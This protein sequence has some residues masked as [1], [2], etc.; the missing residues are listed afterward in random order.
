METNGSPSWTKTEAGKHL[1]ERLSDERTLASLDHLLERI[2]TL[3]QAVDRLA[4]LME[5]GPGLVSMAADTVDETYRQATARG[6]DL[7]QRLSNAAHLAEKLTA[8]ETIERIEGMLAAA[9]KLP[10]MVSMAADVVDETYRQAAEKGVDIEQRLGAALEIAEKL[11][12]PETVEKVNALL[13]LADQAPVMISM[14]ADAMDEEIQHACARGVNIDK[15]LG[16]A[17]RLTER[18]TDPKMEERLN[19]LFDISDQMPGMVAMTVDILD[20]GYR[21]A[22]AQGLDLETLAAQGTFALKQMVELLTSEEFRALMSSGVLSPQTLNVLSQA[23]D[24]LNESQQQE[25][26]KVGLFGTLRALSDSDRKRALGFV[27]TFMKN[28]GKKL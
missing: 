19:T 17:L 3:E 15:R 23:G 27:M 16:T 13:A 14:A 4:T 26:K 18:I 24:A 21:K 10:G 8:P 6:V 25:H 12:A 7:E 22:V 1:Q 2:G 9:D 20:E 28:F 5:Q 11:T